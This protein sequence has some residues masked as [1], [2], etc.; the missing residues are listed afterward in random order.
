MPDILPIQMFFKGEY[1]LLNF[2]YEFGPWLIT[3]NPVLMMLFEKRH[4]VLFFFGVV[5]SIFMR[6]VMMP[7]MLLILLDLDYERMNTEHWLLA[8]AIFLASLLYVVVLHEPV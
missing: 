8:G 5:A 6:R 4:F 3:A 7:V 2:R 1:G